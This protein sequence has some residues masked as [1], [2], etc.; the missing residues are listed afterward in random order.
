MELRRHVER[1]IG[2][3]ALDERRTERSLGSGLS[4]GVFPDSRHVVLV[5]GWGV[6]VLV[7]RS[8]LGGED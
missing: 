8:G 6:E 5:R 2:D 1:S 4:V 3:G 7:V